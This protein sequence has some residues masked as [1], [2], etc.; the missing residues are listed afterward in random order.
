M[1]D[2]LPEAKLAE[3]WQ[4]LL[5]QV[6]DFK[7][8]GNIRLEKAQGFDVAL[9]R[10]EFGA[11]ALDVRVVFD[12]E[13]RIAG[14][15]FVPAAD[16]V[17]YEPPVYS[18]P[19]SFTEE[20]TTVGTGEW[21]LPGTLTVPNGDGPFPAV[22]LVHGSGP[23]DRDETVGPNK[24]FKD[25]AWGLASQGIAVLRYDKRTNQH[26]QRMV[27]LVDGFTVYEETVEDALE[28][29]SLLR[30]TGAIDRQRI[31][32]VG[33]SLGGMLVPRIAALD[34]GIAGFIIMAGAT[35]PIEDMM[36][37]QTSY[38][39]MLD[40]VVTE[41]E[42]AVLDQLKLQVDR[43]KALSDGSPA[44]EL[45]LGAP[46]TYWL[47]LRGYDPASA[48]A[49]IDRP[50]LVLQGDRDYQVTPDHL[51]RWREALSSLDSVEFAVYPT[52][53]H[54]FI[55]GEGPGS[56]TEYQVIGHVAVDVINDIAGWLH[57]R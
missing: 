1:R 18:E 17:G 30:D 10:A 13:R 34:S 44:T 51:E 54:L 12:A 11:T 41:D 14:L 35:E 56:P 24:P 29:V 5:G 2:A 46:A 22:V 23:N 3:T 7:G 32:V 33:H 43:V 8:Q 28:A 45:I 27:A 39:S 20:E 36:L 9:V 53:N 6:G 50:I 19:D 31:F 47:D 57:Q 25:L 49:D 38:L 55:G 26:G 52:L 21:S 15:F 40:G 37:I 42:Q 48:A 16:E 4:A